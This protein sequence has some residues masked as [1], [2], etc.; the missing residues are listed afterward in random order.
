MLFATGADREVAEARKD[1]QASGVDVKA[2]ADPKVA[3]QEVAAAADTDSKYPGL[4]QP[5]RKGVSQGKTNS[6]NAVYVLLYSQKGNDILR[7]ILYSPYF[8]NERK[9]DDT[10]KIR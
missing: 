6:H 9:S 7:H 3:G 1:V 5:Q 2:E 4:I 10:G 8:K